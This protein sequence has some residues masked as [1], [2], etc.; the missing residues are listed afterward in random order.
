MRSPLLSSRSNGGRSTGVAS[1]LVTA[2]TAALLSVGVVVLV[3]GSAQAAGRIGVANESGQAVIDAQYATTLRVSGRGYQAVKGGHGG[4]YVFFGTVKPG[5]RPSQGG[6]TGRD[7]LYVPDS[8]AKNNQGFQKYVAFPGSDTAGSAN[9]G[10]MSM[11]GSWSTTIKVPG[12]VFNAQ[13]R[14]GNVRKID[15]RQVTCGVFTV[16]A[17]GVANASNEAFTPVSV[18]DLT[19]SGQQEGT[20]DD[21]DDEAAK[22]TGVAEDRGDGQ[23][24]QQV[25]PT[26]S[27]AKTKLGPVRLAVDRRS[28]RVGHALSFSAQGLSPRSQ[29][30]AIVDDGVVAAG[31]F[32]VGDDGRITGVL[33]LP[34]DLQP[35]THELRL[36]GARKQPRVRFAVV[37]SETS[38]ALAAED[39]SAGPDRTPLWFLAGCALVLVLAMAHSLRR[40]QR[41]RRAVGGSGAALRPTPAGEPSDSAPTARRRRWRRRTTRPADAQGPAEAAQTPPGESPMPRPAT[42]PAGPPTT[43]VEAD[44]H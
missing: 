41:H 44:A 11:S 5:W 26:S 14:N 33:T 3:P 6:V 16:G 20:T 22:D 9:G 4:I 12:A 1:I 43:K 32:L 8:E 42:P 25:A 29:V 35:G 24:D 30:S 15:C 34:D 37:A 13:D 7:Y 10:S 40:W 18:G 28:A 2:V 38:A 19:G 39:D 17:H 21:T 23:T 31:P 27:P 36:F